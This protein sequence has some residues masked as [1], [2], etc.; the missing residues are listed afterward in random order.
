MDQQRIEALLDTA[1][2]GAV[3]QDIAA[4]VLEHAETRW[5]AARLGSGS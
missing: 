3:S 1:M 4:M 2:F 5:V